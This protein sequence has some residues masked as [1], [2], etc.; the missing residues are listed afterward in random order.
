V[1]K[2]STHAFRVDQNAGT[3]HYI[4]SVRMARKLKIEPK[5]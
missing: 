2:A 4:S 3:R 1:C 5:N